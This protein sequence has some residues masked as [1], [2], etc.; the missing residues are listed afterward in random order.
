MKFVTP[1]HAVVTEAKG[2]VMTEASASSIITLI[3]PQWVAAVSADWAELN[4]NRGQLRCS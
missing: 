2:P 3:T 4:K 1:S